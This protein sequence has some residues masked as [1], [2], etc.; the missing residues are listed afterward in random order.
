MT[1]ATPAFTTSRRHSVWQLFD[2]L[3]PWRAA[4]IA[5]LIG[6]AL[7]LTA[8]RLFIAYVLKLFVDAITTRTLDVL[9]YS[10]EIWLVFL[11]VWIP[12]NTLL[13]YWWRAVT[14]RAITNL[15]Q[16]VFSHLQR[17]PLGYHEQR[18]T[19]DLVSVLTNDVT[20]A[21]RAF[22]QDML[23][24][25][26]ATLQGISA[27]VFMLVLNWQLALVIIGS[28]F[29]PLIVNTLFAG[30]LRHA[31]EAVQARLGEM[32]E[33]L[34]DLLA[35]SQVVRTYNLE[36]WIRAHFGRANDALLQSSLHRV[37]L[38]SLLAG[39]NGLGLA[40]FV[41]PMAAGAYMVLNG[42]TTFGVLI[43]LVQLNN[44]IQF[45]V[46]SLGGTITRIQAA[47]A[48][49]DRILAVL[50]AP[51][52]PERY[53]EEVISIPAQVASRN[54]S[55]SNAL[56]AFDNVTFAY[57]DGKPVLQG[58]SFAVRQGQVAAF[59]GPSGGGKSTLFKL[60]LGCYPLRE[61]M[62]WVHQ[63]AINTCRLSDLRDQFAYIPQDA[64]LYA[65]SIMDNIRYGKAGATNEEVIAAARAAYAHDFISAFPEGYNTRVGERG[66]RL[67][68][69][70]RQRI[71]IAR[72]LLKDAP[73]LL[74]DEATSA[75]DSE[76]E[77]L[78]QQALD[79][80]MRGRTVLVIAHRL[81]TIE[82][83]DMIYV[84]DGGHVVEAGTQAELMQLH[85]LFHRL[86][87]LQFS[88]EARG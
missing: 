16:R 84:V 70:Q 68:G 11:V 24:L 61:G 86:H 30:P 20:T 71:A 29:I 69:G 76:S 8:E 73:V 40:T 35:G 4:Y 75:L 21:E 33:R 56:L 47:L 39:A 77:A 26:N 79:V 42:Q 62:V 44:P 51:R 46:Q 19:G 3:K 87:D 25:V 88:D 83:A 72:A 27:A 66:A 82:H 38:E 2:F 57:A 52:E 13:S 15:R 41:L 12:L 50:E 28:G 55:G 10:V 49:A 43:A 22:Q 6:L 74:L 32:S 36:Q 54:G 80:L 85:G 65:G 9:W 59:V 23:D 78:V 58:M 1:N 48:G 53:Q 31:G 60:L 45:F 14:L 34:S 63:Q 81:S 64:Y 17:L 5:S 67:S 7:V 37:K 18:H